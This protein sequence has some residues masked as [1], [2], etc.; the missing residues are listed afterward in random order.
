MKL[1]ILSLSVRL[2]V[3]ALEWN[4]CGDQ[5]SAVHFQKFEVEPKIVRAG[6]D[7]TANVSLIIDHNIGERSLSDL[8]IWRIIAFFGYEFNWKIGC[9][10]GYGSCLR[11]LSETIKG[12]K[13]LCLWYENIIQKPCASF[14]TIESGNYE[15]NNFKTKF[16]KFSGIAKFFI[17]GK[18]RVRWQWR[19]GNAT[20]FSCF[21]TNF[22]I[23]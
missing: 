18:Y 15:V 19:Y 13:L 1:F 2:V 11:D 10:L 21:V 20:S 4:D 12:N 9:F 7:V 17:D 5:W 23:N 3:E 22:L 14:T 6:E 16:P 8:E